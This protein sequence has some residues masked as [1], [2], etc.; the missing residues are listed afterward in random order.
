[1]TVTQKNSSFAQQIAIDRRGAPY[2]YGG[3]WLPLPL[4]NKIGTDC[5]G[6]VTDILDAACNGTA[7][8]WTRHGLSTESWRPPSMGG[9]ADISN[10]PFG[11]VMCPNNDPNQ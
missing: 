7:M 9:A 8:E 4:G 2:V 3:N 1:M 11:T 6:C 10:G 5:S